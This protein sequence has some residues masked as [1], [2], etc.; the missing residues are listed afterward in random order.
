[1]RLYIQFNPKTWIASCLIC[2]SLIACETKEPE[3]PTEVRTAEIALEEAGLTKT[4]LDPERA[5]EIEKAAMD[6]FAYQEGKWTSKWDWLGPDGKLLGTLEG[7]ETFSPLVDGYSQMLTNTVP[8]MNQTS[9]A[10]LSYNPVEQ[11][12][13]FLNV[14]AGGDYWIMKQD[15]ETGTMISDPHTNPD[16]SVTLLRFTTLR[17]EPN[18]MDIQME[19]SMDGGKTWTIGFKQSMTRV[20][21]E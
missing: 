2:V 11:K 20:N 15:P 19:S 13:A 8:S 7:T 16:G 6:L 18:E 21:A 12:I 10:M 4:D 1:M 14:G 9:Y 17:Q 5:D 3:E